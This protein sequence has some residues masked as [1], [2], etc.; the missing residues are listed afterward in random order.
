MTPKTNAMIYLKHSYIK[1]KAV[2]VAVSREYG[3]EHV[4]VYNNSINKIKFKIFLENLR[5]KYQ[6]DDIMFVMDNLSLLKSNEVKERMQELGFLYSL[7][8]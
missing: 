4:E 8:S 6:F 7:D 3:L 2:I 1:A 5:S